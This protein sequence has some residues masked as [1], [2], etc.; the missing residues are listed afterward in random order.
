MYKYQYSGHFDMF[1]FFSFA[2]FHKQI[3]LEQKSS[4]FAARKSESHYI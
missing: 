1:L 3:P 2:A 4:A